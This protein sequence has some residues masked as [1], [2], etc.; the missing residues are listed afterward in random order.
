MVENER[1]EWDRPVALPL[2]HFWKHH[3]LAPWEEQ[4][5]DKHGNRFVGRLVIGA[6]SRMGP[7]GD[8]ATPVVPLSKTVLQNAGPEDIIY[9]PLYDGQDPTRALTVQE[10]LPDHLYA[11]NLEIL[12]EIAPRVKAILLGNCGPEMCFMDYDGERIVQEIRGRDT[13]HVWRIVDGHRAFIEATAPMVLDAGGT[14]AYAPM[15]YEVMVDVYMTGRDRH[16]KKRN[17]APIRQAIMDV[18]AS[19]V[20]FLG[21]GEWDQQFR[22]NLQYSPHYCPLMARP[23]LPTWRA[24]LSA[25]GRALAGTGTGCDRRDLPHEDDR[26]CERICSGVISPNLKAY[27]AGF[28]WS[29]CGMEFKDGLARG[30]DTKALEHGYDA[31]FMGWP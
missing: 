17:P 25:A 18:G 29:T 22:P 16:G 9:V 4:K 23:K 14:P 5:P 19:F 21:F 27:L 13:D 8:G 12:Q 15:P 11:R 6:D 3:E 2:R 26:R 30:N 10:R 1:L 20:Q 31:G 28:K 24:R 7:G